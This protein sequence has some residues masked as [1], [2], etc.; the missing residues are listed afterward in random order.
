MWILPI[1]HKAHGGDPVSGRVG[2]GLGSATGGF[3]P[4]P[5][6]SLWCRAGAGGQAAT[7]GAASGGE[8][9]AG[10]DRTPRHPV[11]ALVTNGWRRLD[12]STSTEDS[13][14]QPLRYLA[15]GV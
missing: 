2:T 5:W 10:T 9:A 14:P 1:T 4:V 13:L 8:R 3:L 6:V 7:T 15:L 11:S 12:L